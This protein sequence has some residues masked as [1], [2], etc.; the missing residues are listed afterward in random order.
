MNNSYAVRCHPTNGQAI[1]ADIQANEQQRQSTY[2]ASLPYIY[3]TKCLLV[4]VCEMLKCN[5]THTH[6]YVY[7]YVICACELI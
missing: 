3:V 5:F 4:C 1:C 2:F 6:I 7:I